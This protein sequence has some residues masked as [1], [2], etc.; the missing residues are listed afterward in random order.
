MRTQLELWKLVRENFDMYFETGL[1]WVIFSLF[2]NYEIT[3]DEYD[4]LALDLK[5]EGN[6]SDF[7]LGKKGDPKPRLEFI[8]K[9]IKKHSKKD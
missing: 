7:F 1:C 5:N 6:A 8:E 9:M 2:Y 4:S 3:P